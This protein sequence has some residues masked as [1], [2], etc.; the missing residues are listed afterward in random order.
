MKYCQAFLFEVFISGRTVPQGSKFREFLFCWKT[1]LVL[2]VGRGL[3][4]S[5][6][7]QGGGKHKT[8]FAVRLYKVS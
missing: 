7:L 2:N 1:T 8:A 3:L 5:F 6:N 4:G